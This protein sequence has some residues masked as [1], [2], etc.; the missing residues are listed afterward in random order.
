MSNININKD[1]IPGNND[2][3]TFRSK[4]SGLNLN[5]KSSKKERKKYKQTYHPLLHI[6]TQALR[7]Q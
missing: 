7:V 5:L 2:M 6:Y 1:A 4:N 3:M